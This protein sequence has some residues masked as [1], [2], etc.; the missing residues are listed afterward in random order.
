MTIKFNARTVDRLKPI[1]GK[2]CE[3]F[4]AATPGLALRVTE[5]GVKSWSV[6]YRHRGRLRRLTLGGAD[7]VKLADA[8]SRARDALNA[9]SEGADPAADKQQDKKAETIADLAT[10]YI[11]R[12]AKKRKKSWKEDDRILR[13]EVL[14][15]WKQRAIADIKRRDV[16]L[17]VEAIAERGAPIM[18][19]RTTALLSKV[20]KFAMDDELIE[21]SPAVRISRPAPEQKRDRVLSE[22]EIRQLWK[23][24][25]AL[26]R[27]MGT[28]FKLRLVT[29]Q[30]GG[31]VSSMCWEDVDLDAAWWT[32]PAA[33]SKN[34]LTHRVPLNA[35]A[36]KLLQALRP[37]TDAEGF[38]LAGG[39]GR[40]QQSEAAGT[41]QVPN[42]R[43]HDLRRTAASLMTGGGIPR[44][45]VGK[46]LNHVEA[47]VTAVYDRH[48]YDAEKAAA[49]AWWD[50][51]LTAIL[52]NKPA[53]VL[54]F[55]KGA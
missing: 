51:K 39:R 31:E 19:N 24:F 25:E 46:I 53:T 44:L 14:P 32:I 34:K 16:R 36:L 55:V 22:T 9:A 12:Y 8:R 1:P 2:R 10:E 17:L 28:Y 23:A 6:L 13:A 37:A 7:V 3:Y 20:F 26:P 5:N 48:G 15:H 49:V 4:D 11:E 18:A 38:V 52:E 30:R 50:R 33:R 29:A 47:G 42:F 40:R 35:T 27:E 45:I 21:A 43:G 41:F 54:P